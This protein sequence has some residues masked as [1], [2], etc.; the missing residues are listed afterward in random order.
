MKLRRLCTALL[1]GLSFC[2]L[3]AATP[4]ATTGDTASTLPAAH[5]AYSQPALSPD[6]RQLAFVA[7][8]AIWTVG[9]QGGEAHLLVS[10]DIGSNARPLYAPDGKQLAFETTASNGDGGIYVLDLDSGKLQR[11]TWSDAPRH[12]DAWS[13]DGRWLYFSTSLNN[14]NGFNGIYRISCD[15]GTP[16]PVSRETYRDQEMAAP[17]PD[18]RQLA[19]VGGGLGSWQWWRHG[20]AHIDEGAIW[21]TELD[22]QHHYRRL[23]ADNARAEWPM[24]GPDPGQLFYLSDRGGSEN[25]WRLDLHGNESPVTHFTDGRVLWPSLAG[26]GSMLA[27]ERNFEIWT[28]SATTG[29]SRPLSIHLNG[30]VRSPLQQHQTVSGF[31]ALALSPDGKKLALIS[32]GAIFITDA[33]K[34][35]YARQLEQAPGNAYDLAWSPDSSELAFGAGDDSSLYSYRLATDTLHKLSRQPGQYSAPSYAPDGKQ[36]AFVRN[37][38]ELDVL[39]LAKGR[40]QTLATASIELPRPLN[41]PRPLAWSPDSRWIAY[42]SWGQRMFRNVQAVSVRDGHRIQLS[43]LAN[44]SAQDVLW[45]SDRIHLLFTTGQRTESSQVA[46]ISLVNPPPEFREDALQKLLT[47]KP[48]DASGHKHSRQDGGSKRDTAATPPPVNIDAAGIADRLELLPIGL[49]A[50]GEQ[51]SPDGKS[52]LFSAEVAGSTNLY[53]WPLDPLAPLPH[54]ARQLTHTPGPKQ[55]PQFTADG[56]QVYYLDHDQV[57]HLALDG[58]QAQAQALNVQATM[59]VDFQTQKMT[60]FEEAWRWLRDTFHDPAMNGV[61]W[62]E[63][64]RRYAPLIAACTDQASLYILL[65]QMVGELNASHSGAYPPGLAPPHTGYLGLDFD[66]VEYQ[67]HGRLRIRSILAQSPAAAAGGIQPGDYLLEVDG[68]PLDAHSNLAEW[69]DHRIGERTVL[70]VARQ[71]S[72]PVRR[73]AVK[74]VDRTT[75]AALEY[76]AW[77]NANRAYVAR[78]SG[79]RLGYVHLADMSESSLQDFYKTLDAENATRQGVVIDVRNNFGGFVNAYALDVLSRRPYIN[80]TYR[81]F[82]EAE[83]ARSI[84][85]QRALERPTVLVTNRVT[86]SDGEDFTEGYR[87]MGLGKVVGEPTAGWIIYTSAGRLVDGGRVRLPFITVTDRHGQSLE[88]HPRPVDVL[89]KRPLGES[90]TGK[91]SD[92]DAAVATLLDSTESSTREAVST[93]LQTRP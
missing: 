55:D 92:L 80:M 47:A 45:S 25:I 60:V 61:D 14:V 63:V 51:I 28:T 50:E 64:H 4:A 33:V 18:G 29:Q 71:P 16:M 53:V 23:S 15:G 1:M 11:L 27:F 93:P 42:L 78:I 66:P 87:S 54:V 82:S 77:V 68:H 48:A 3:D 69:L 43:Q 65:D 85:G 73:I 49:D 17:S 13:R 44:T 6:G 46:R 24:W 9:S 57:F 10:T 8:G 74:P 19:L 86:L 70:G 37:G 35:G 21:L 39:D 62:D 90:Y 30:I 81:G 52:L 26:D 41:G 91:D 36:L 22:G 89:V 7:N 20:H 72:G 2:Q 40:I 59:D 34:G 75:I 67:Q 88:Q 38:H 79:G 31:D 56:K 83:P 5:P 12:L 58:G 76:R 32:H 84:L